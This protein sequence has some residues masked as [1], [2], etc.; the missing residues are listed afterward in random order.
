MFTYNIKIYERNRITSVKVDSLSYTLKLDESLDSGVLTIPRSTRRDKFNRF[1]R[2]EISINDSN[3]I[4]N[5]TWLIYTTKVEIDN[6]LYK[7]YNHTI[8]LIEPTKWLEKFVVGTL[9][10]TQPLTGTQKTLYDYI[11]RVRQI[12]PLVPRA[13]VFSTR[14]FKLDP[15]FIEKINNVIAPQMYLDKKNLREVLV[16]LFKVVN[17]I[18]RLYYNNGWWLTGDFINQKQLPIEIG[19]GDIDYIQEASGEN[20]G[21]SAEI[22][23]ENTI[24]T[25]NVIY[26]GS[27]TD[28]ITFRNNDVILGDNDLRLVLSQPT[29][30]LKNLSI[31]AFTNVPLNDN[32]AE[33][34]LNDYV[35]EKKVYD[36]LEFD[37]G[38]GSQGYSVYW[39]YK[40]NEILGFSESFGAIFQQI[41]AD[42]IYADLYGESV[43]L[44]DSSNWKTMLFKVE[45]VPYYETMRSIQ[46]RENFEPY[47]LKPEMLDE[48]SG[49]II[50][51]SERINE[52]YDLTEN[53]YGQIQ[54]IGVDTVST[55]KK[56]YVFSGVYN[57]G[58]YTLDS[59]YVTKVEIIPYTTYLIARYELSKNW[60]RISQFVQID[61][62]FR[63]YEVSL[64]KSAFTLKRDI[65]LPLAF[66]ELS[67]ESIV[68][69]SLDYDEL[70]KRFLETLKTG[71][72]NNN[73]TVATIRP[74]WRTQP[75]V[76]P[77]GALA[78]KNALKWKLDMLD[79][80]LAGKQ[81][82][83]EENRYV[84]K[85]IYY[86]TTRGELENV[87]F[88]LYN[89]I[90][91]KIDQNLD[92][93]NIKVAYETIN[94]Q[95]VKLS[96]FLPVIEAR[97]GHL[98]SQLPIM[99]NETNFNILEYSGNGSI[100][101]YYYPS[102]GDFPNPIINDGFYIAEDTYIVYIG[103]S[104]TNTY[105]Q[106]AYVLAKRQEAVFETPEYTIKKDNA[107][108][109][110]FEL[111]LPVVARYDLVN[112][113]VIGDSLL[114][115]N[116][117]IK[118]RATSK[119][120]YFYGLTQPIEKTQSDKIDLTTAT[121]LENTSGYVTTNYVGIPA[122]VYLPFN[123]FAIAD[124][125]GNLYLGVNQMQFGSA[126][127]PITRI[128]FNFL[129]T[130]TA[131][132]VEVTEDVALNIEMFDETIVSVELI[133]TENVVLSFAFRDSDRMTVVEREVENVILNLA[134]R[135][136][137][138]MAI[139]T[140][141][142]ESDSLILNLAFRDN[143]R[144]SATY[145]ATNNTVE[146]LVSFVSWESFGPNYSYNF[147]VKNNDET[148]AEIFADTTA[149]PT[150]SKGVI[151]SRSS[152]TVSVISSLSSVTLYARAKATGENYSTID[153]A[154][155]AIT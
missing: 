131:P 145:I 109:L 29:A 81:V 2:V 108:I 153:S 39:T 123:Y 8:G 147:I 127:T 124:S 106:Y 54:R 18:P 41:A 68:D 53:V 64:S 133:Y 136:N 55:S 35:F 72:Y 57:V 99:T 45:Y 62:E 38:K 9:T 105:Q 47:A 37:N 32:M 96:D 24:P 119:T 3:E 139:T 118:P 20:F 80:K 21:Q 146:P 34:S 137:D 101:I 43:S 60:N 56:H 104:S 49:I 95:F 115:E 110:G 85:A 90:W 141:F 63:P 66:V 17:A 129:Q 58:D 42:R 84:Q 155:G 28:Y 83:Y 154:S 52:L 130:R 91:N 69:S 121:Q 77:L 100:E 138:R 36:T 33:I 134:L 5:T 135:D 82:V 19:D 10:F 40:S 116:T 74:R 152:V 93:V 16:E 73:I 23:H 107:E 51:P 67:T 148:A 78:E 31:Y 94:E 86:T 132:S 4:K 126:K 92:D 76:K 142:V 15:D 102:A 149:T 65:L 75:I 30:E 151:A 27:V 112:T 71:T 12:V 25:D 144:I 111:T 143:D 46:Y 140:S 14:L 103:Y 122:S 48:Y 1:S 70:R 98:I 6:R 26:E 125:D 150:S 11:E 59:Y 88:D 89:G 79:T 44:I 50:N 128:Y 87:N 7:T 97:W 61:R 120:L 13:R 22:F 114:K 113:F 117:L